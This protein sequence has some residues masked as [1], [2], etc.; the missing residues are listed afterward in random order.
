MVAISKLPP[1]LCALLPRVD[2]DLDLISLSFSLLVFIYESRSCISIISFFFKSNRSEFISCFTPLIFSFNFYFLFS[3]ISYFMR[4]IF[5]CFFDF[6]TFSN[7]L[8]F[9]ILI[10]YSETILSCSYS[11]SDIIVSLLFLNTCAISWD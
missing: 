4:F 8:R 7:W 9:L 10:W 5:S 11:W 1:L 3:S 6:I 2:I